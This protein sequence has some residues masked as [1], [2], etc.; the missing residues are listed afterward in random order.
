MQ[1]VNSTNLLTA[2]SVVSDMPLV[3]GGVV[4]VPTYVA[5]TGC[6]LGLGYYDLFAVTNGTFPTQYLSAIGL[7]VTADIQVGSGAAFT[8]SVTMTGTAGYQLNNGSQNCTTLCGA[9]PG[10]A[11]KVN[12]SISWRQH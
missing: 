3:V 1:V 2:N 5:G 9:L 8:P 11:N 12:T 7:S 6:S 10:T 4:I